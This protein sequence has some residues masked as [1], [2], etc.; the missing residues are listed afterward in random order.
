MSFPK[1]LQRIILI[2]A[3]CLVAIQGPVS[4]AS[5]RPLTPDDLFHLE[6]IGTVVMAPDGGA[7]AFVRVRPLLTARSYQHHQYWIGG[8]DR[9][10]IWIASIG[11]GAA[12]NITKGESDGSGYWKPMWSPDGK[13]IAMLST[14]GGGDNP[15]LWIWEK[16][17][18]RLSRLSERGI[19]F[20]TAAP[21][22]AWVDNERLVAVLRPE[23]EKSP[24][25]A[26]DYI[27]TVAVREWAKT[28]AGKQPAASVLDSGVPVDLASRPQ[29][30]VALIDVNGNTQVIESAALFRDISVAPDH[31]KVAFL[32]QVSRDQPDP[33]VLLQHRYG[34]QYESPLDWY[35]PEIVDSDGHIAVGATSRTISIYLP[36]S[37][38]WAPDSHAFAFIGTVRDGGG[39]V[40]RVFRGTVGGSIN[41]VKLDEEIT[42]YSLVWA[43]AD[44]LLLLAE[45]KV[46]RSVSKKKRLDWW[47]LH[48]SRAPQNLT[49]KL[50]AVPGD[51]LTSSDGHTL[52]G[53]AG[54]A[55]WRLDIESVGWR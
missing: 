33:A 16:D 32:K 11:G 12:T 25:S 17:T 30:Q 51:L 26:L 38:R 52:L 22:F 2:C 40:F 29:E 18:S 44:R 14:K 34:N 4:A 45:R 7:F 28:K 5:Q 49:A 27:T 37:F 54:G 9:A 55:L 3:V 53:T 36:G 43:D 46:A 50:A 23:E 13:R 8:G 10:D 48:L 31:H 21:G 41:P 42:P 35:Q 39:D 15:R 24:P 6:E 20:W 1:E 47:L 19:A